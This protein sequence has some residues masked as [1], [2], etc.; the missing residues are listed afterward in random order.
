MRSYELVTVFPVEEEPFRQGKENVAAELARQGARNVKEDDMGDRP[1]A[2]PI[3]KKA[4][5]HYILYSMEFPGENVDAAEKAFKLNPN[6][7]RYLFV[8]AGA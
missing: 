6:L 8:R 1:L 2:Y 5:G 4:R 7:L 3:R